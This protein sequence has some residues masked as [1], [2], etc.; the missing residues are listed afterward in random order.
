MV[1]IS[2]NEPRQPTPT[3]HLAN[4]LVESQARLSPIWAT[5]AG[6]T[7]SEA[8]L[9]DFSPDAEQD[10]ADLARHT[11]AALNQTPPQD[12]TDRITAAALRERLGLQLELHQASEFA[13]DL[14]N[15]DSPIQLV[16]DVF[17]LMPRRSSEDWAVIAR[18][19]AAVPTSLSSYRKALKQGQRQAKVPAER[20]VRAGIGQCE[21]LAGPEGPLAMLA[22]EGETKVE[23]PL[24]KDLEVAASQARQ[25]YAKL[26]E[27]LAGSL[28]QDAPTRDAVGRERYQ[29]L[30]RYFTGSELDLDQTYQWGLDQLEAIVEEQGALAAKLYGPGTAVEQ[31]YQRLDQD[32]RYLVAGTAALLLVAWTF[33]FAIRMQSS[34]N[35]DFKNAIGQTGTVYITVPAALSGRGKV[36]LTLQ[37]RFLELPAM[38]AA[39]KPLR[40]GQLVTVTDLVDDNTLLVEK[41]T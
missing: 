40:P 13:R 30:S 34:G 22:N 15:I 16:R 4:Q 9:D 11:L 27:F 24:A 38:T 28:A 35:V 1:Q 29:L 20:Q 18:R 39:H 32:P 10:R 14:N 31:A 37:E 12:N 36:T 25:A 23:K 8:A 19:L 3:D 7:N 21:D 2:P 33:R 41:K 5:T 6:I 17:D 26:A